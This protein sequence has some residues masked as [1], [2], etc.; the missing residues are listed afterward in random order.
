[1]TGEKRCRKCNWL[2]TEANWA[3]SSK[4]KHDNICKVCK[5]KELNNIQPSGDLV[6][7]DNFVVEK[8]GGKAP[9]VRI[10]DGCKTDLNKIIDATEKYRI[11]EIMKLITGGNEDKVR[12]V[13]IEYLLQ[14]NRELTQDQLLEVVNQANKMIYTKSVDDDTKVKMIVLLRKFRA[15]DDGTSRRPATYESIMKDTGEIEIDEV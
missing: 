4:R 15:R 11:E 13:A 6:E 7:Y 1:M 12:R 14:A 2:L 8:P 10:K 3:K 9:R 5:A